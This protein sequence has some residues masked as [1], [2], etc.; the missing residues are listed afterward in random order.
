MGRKEQNY[1]KKNGE[2]GW[3]YLNTHIN[4]HSPD[5]T[6]DFGTLLRPLALWTTY[7]PFRRYFVKTTHLKPVKNYQTARGLGEDSYTESGDL[8]DLV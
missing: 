5:K 3:S 7:L 4:R 1:P 6:G 2:N 8:G